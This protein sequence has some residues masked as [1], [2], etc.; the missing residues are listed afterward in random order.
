MIFERVAEYIA[1]H[2][3]GKATADE[4]K[5]FEKEL[6]D[7]SIIRDFD[8]LKETLTTLLADGTDD[9][10]NLA[11]ELAGAYN[12]DF[13]ICVICGDVM[14]NGYVYNGYKY[15][16][17]KKCLYTDFDEDGWYEECASNEESYYTEW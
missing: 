9:G 5:Q 8:L 2:N 3:R 16:C 7:G 11:D 6:L 12:T 10:F 14:L 15:Y 13:R 4:K 1:D 17:S